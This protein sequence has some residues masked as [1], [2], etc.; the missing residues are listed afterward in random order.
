M[1]KTVDIHSGRRIVELVNV[2]EPLR[3]SPSPRFA[4]FALTGR[5]FQHRR[6]K[7]RAFAFLGR[8]L[9]VANAQA[10]A[11][12]GYA[13]ATSKMDSSMPGPAPAATTQA[14][15]CRQ[16]AALTQQTGEC[17][18]RTQRSDAAHDPS[19]A[20]LCRDR[21]EPALRPTMRLAHERAP[22]STNAPLHARSRPTDVFR[23]FGLAE[24]PSTMSGATGSALPQS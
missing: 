11:Q 7:S 13:L 24:V 3:Q 5:W 23:R 1:K 21:S 10:D 4:S 8:C 17:R 22:A 14:P 20:A 6:R 9:W 12:R 16:G 2:L 19:G 15:F 18:R